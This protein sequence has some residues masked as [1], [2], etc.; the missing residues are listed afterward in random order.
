[1]RTNHIAGVAPS[2]QAAKKPRKNAANKLSVDGTESSSMA[3]DAGQKKSRGGSKRAP[4]K[5][6]SLLNVLAILEA[7]SSL[8]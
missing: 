7:H 4:A 5:K 1:M 8:A 6:V 2:K 3:A